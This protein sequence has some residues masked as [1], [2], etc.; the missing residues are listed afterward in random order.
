M[1]FEVFNRQTREKLD[2]SAFAIIHRETNGNGSVSYTISL[3]SDG[4]VAQPPLMIFSSWRFSVSNAIKDR[5]GLLVSDAPNTVFILQ[6]SP[7]ENDAAR[8]FRAEVFP[9]RSITLE[10]ISNGELVGHAVVHKH[11]ACLRRFEDICDKSALS[12]RQY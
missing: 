1:K 12:I 5:V 6:F 8:T 7:F 4:G 11:E 3:E 9:Q 10:R 2:E